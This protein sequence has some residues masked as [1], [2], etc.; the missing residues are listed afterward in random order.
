MC[1]RNACN[2]K[3]AELA[4]RFKVVFDGHVD[5]E[6]TTQALGFAHPLWPVV[7]TER[8]DTLDFMHW[9]LIPHWV[10]TDADALDISNKTLNARA[11]TVFEKPSFRDSVKLR[12]CLVASTGFYEFR[13]EGKTKTPYFIRLKDVEVFAMAGTYSLWTDSGGVIHRTFSII[14][15]TANPLMARIH[16]VG[17]RM[18]VI[19]REEDEAVWIDQKMDLA[20]VGDLLKPFHEESMIAVE[21]GAEELKNPA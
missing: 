1:Y 5:W 17:Q 16:N 11:E 2:I 9:G 20:K 21:V 6:P 10:K 7:G 15:T 18:P 4:K 14:T 13:T 8:S 12:R 19:L 3:A